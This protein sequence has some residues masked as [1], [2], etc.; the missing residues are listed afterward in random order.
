MLDIGAGSGIFVE[1]ALRL[2]YDAEGVEPSEWLVNRSRERG[3]PVH[4]GVL[5]LEAVTA[6]FDV[7]TLIDVIEHV[8]DPV[9]LLR[10]A[11]DVMKPGGIG[12]VVTPDV[13]SIAARL[14]GPRWWHYRVAHVCYFAPSTLER[15][16]T[17]T[18]FKPL[19]RF[20]PAWYFTAGYLLDRLAVYFKP[21]RYLNTR[22][23]AQFTVPLNL[24][25]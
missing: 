4:R 16:L 10:D 20:R 25:D 9:R 12:L 17:L 7:V 13:S 5:P 22:L 6:P 21:V 18:G 24:Y 1:Q 19:R 11:R 14:M 23:A 2:G 8:T 15:A 3:L